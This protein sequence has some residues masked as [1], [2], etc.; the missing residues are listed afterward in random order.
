MP[1]FHSPLGSQCSN[2]QK[3]CL[4]EKEKVTKVK[5][6]VTELKRKKTFASYISDKRLITGLYRELK[7]LNSQ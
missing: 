2:E 1:P 3:M 7:T 5:S 6:S 4:I